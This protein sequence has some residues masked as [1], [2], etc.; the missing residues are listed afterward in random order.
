[1]DR[2]LSFFCNN[3]NFAINRFAIK[4]SLLYHL[5]CYLPIQPVH[6]EG[7][8]PIQPVHSEGYLPI[9]PVHSEDYLPIQPVHSEGYLP[10]QPVH[11]EGY[12]PIQTVHSEGYLP[13]QPVH[14]ESYLPIQPVH[15]EGCFLSA[16]IVF[17]FFLCKAKHKVY[18]GSKAL[19]CG[20]LWRFGH[21]SI[22]YS[23]KSL[24]YFV[25][26]TNLL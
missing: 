14:S 7:Y 26:S 6:S 17:L 19:K 8:L 24:S 3:T 1:M 21:T 2:C 23:V 15:S 5:K 11:S 12:L 13:I 4:W 22:T 18:L 16:W 9:Q 25:D 20:N 10:I